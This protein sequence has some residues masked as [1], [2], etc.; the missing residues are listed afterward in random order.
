M[1]KRQCKVPG[2]ISRT[3]EPKVSK[4][5]TDPMDPWSFQPLKKKINEM[6]YDE[7]SIYLQIFQKIDRVK[8]VMGIILLT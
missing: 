3:C 7:K 1:N 5:G 2:N 4:R 8:L 6:M